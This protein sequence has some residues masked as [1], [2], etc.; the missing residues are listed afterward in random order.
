MRYGPR[1]GTEFYPF[2]PPVWR[3][4]QNANA[5]DPPRLCAVIWTP[6]VTCYR[7]A[8][9]E[10]YRVI[11]TEDSWHHKCHFI[12]AVAPNVAHNGLPEDRFDRSEIHRTLQN[13]F[14]CGPMQVTLF[15]YIER[16]LKTIKNGAV[17]KVLGQNLM[18]I[19]NSIMVVEN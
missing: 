14:I 8:K 17:F 6:D 19:S 18:K 7:A 15:D 9:T 13:V 2:G 11:D 16:L 12:S 4:P 5:T 10:G 1:D 3:E